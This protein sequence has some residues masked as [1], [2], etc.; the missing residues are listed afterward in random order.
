MS[1]EAKEALC[2]LKA[3]YKLVCLVTGRD[4][5]RAAEM[6]GFRGLAYIGSHGLEICVDGEFEES[7]EAKRYAGIM[8]EVAAALSRR[9]PSTGIEI[10]AKKL[11]LGVHYRR[12]EDP[13]WARR[14][15]LVAAEPLLKKYGLKGVDAR[16][17]IE[18]RPDIPA[19]KGRAISKVIDRKKLTSAVYFGDDATDI[20]A[21]EAMERVREKGGYTVKVAVD[22]PEAPPG[23]LERA[24]LVLKGV[25]EVISVFTWLAA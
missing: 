12:A 24:D 5:E 11:A 4:L 6:A 22:S 17:A 14:A 19:N 1:T 18:L 9:L 23:L 25:G 21:F 13:E 2:N 15:I 10:E 7:S 20:S 3:S 8:P 16:K